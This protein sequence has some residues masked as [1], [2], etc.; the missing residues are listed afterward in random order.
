[1]I[2]S[3]VIELTKEKQHFV[4]LRRESYFQ[5]LQKYRYNFNR[6]VSLDRLCFYIY[7]YTYMI[8][9]CIYIFP[10]G[11]MYME[12][13]TIILFLYIIATYYSCNKN[14]KL[15]CCVK[16]FCIKSP[17]S[18]VVEEK[19]KVLRLKKIY[20]LDNI[21]YYSNLLIPMYYVVYC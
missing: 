15:E 4:C 14:S 2:T 12:P 21:I 8:L 9:W 6:R 5:S 3:H 7:V 10:L 18:V 11:T 17:K 13:S 19:N 16:N 20:F 1:L